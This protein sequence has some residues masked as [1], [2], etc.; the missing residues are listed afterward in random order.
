[1]E[2]EAEGARRRTRFPVDAAAREVIMGLFVFMPE[3][4]STFSK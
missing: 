2:I 4:E 3:A 1:M